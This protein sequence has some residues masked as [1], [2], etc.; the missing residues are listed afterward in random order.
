MAQEDSLC[1]L[2]NSGFADE[3]FKEYRKLVRYSKWVCKDCGRTARKRVN[4]CNPK[5]LYPKHKAAK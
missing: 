1:D 4:L 5:R 3:R 2:V